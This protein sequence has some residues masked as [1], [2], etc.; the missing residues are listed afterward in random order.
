MLKG[1]SILRLHDFKEQGKSFHEISRITGHSRNTVRKYVRDGHTGQPAGR[2]P[3]G[4]ILDEFKPVIDQWMAEGLFNCKVILERLRELGYSGGYTTV[5]DYVHPHRPPK[6]Q[7]AT[8]RYETKPGEQAQVDWGICEYQTLYG[9]RKKVPVF[10]MVLGHSRMIYVEFTRRCDIYSLLRCFVHAF[11]YFGGIPKIVLT[12]RMKTVLLGVNDDH[13]PNWHPLF[14]DF[15]LTVGFIPR[16]CKARKPQ[17]KGKVERGIRFVKEN[18]WPE[19]QFTDL[20]DLNRQ[21]RGWCEKANRRVH[22]TTGRRPI[23]MLNEE[24]LQPLTEP[25]KLAQFLREE[26]KVSSDGFVSFDGVKYGVPWQYSGRIVTVRQVANKVEVWL[27]N[28]RIAVHEKANGSYVRLP[29]Q[30]EGLLSAGGET[31]PKP[32]AKQ[33][34]ETKVEKRPLAIYEHLAGIGA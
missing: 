20:D 7:K 6:K 12:D 18:F 10:V 8:I 9:E 22:G 2:A 5:K 31:Y 4:S 27:D 30:Y 26:R 11:E 14:Q 24:Q 13:T 33:I 15:A 19:R 21:A 28:Q 23:D 32:L 3:K 34:G 17:T 1:G 16:V 29:A 25:G